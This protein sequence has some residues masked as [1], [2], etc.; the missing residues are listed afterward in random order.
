[1]YLYFES[2]AKNFTAT[3]FGLF[4]YFQD[5]PVPSVEGKSIAFLILTITIPSLISGIVTIA[6]EYFKS[7]RGRK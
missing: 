6:V 1:M 7:K 2:L 4:F 5:V 3:V